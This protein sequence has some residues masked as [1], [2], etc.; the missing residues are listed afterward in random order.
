MF[1]LLGGSSLWRNWPL[2]AGENRQLWHV[3]GI[4]Q[5]WLP[6]ALVEEPSIVCAWNSPGGLAQAYSFGWITST[7]PHLNHDRKPL[8]ENT[9]HPYGKAMDYL[10]IKLCLVNLWRF[11]LL[12]NSQEMLKDLFILIDCSRFDRIGIQVLGITELGR[13]EQYGSAVVWRWSIIRNITSDLCRGFGRQGRWTN[14]L[15][16]NIESPWTRIRKSTGSTWSCIRNSHQT[17]V[18]TES[19]QCS[20]ANSMNGVNWIANWSFWIA[21]NSSSS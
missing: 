4:A 12:I 2:K 6:F 14:A 3:R 13:A 20:K 10:T 16:E 15:L 9:G 21:W 8:D 18:A 19:F 7:A 1:I 5:R 11:W 17:A